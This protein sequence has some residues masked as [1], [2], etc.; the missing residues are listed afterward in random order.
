MTRRSLCR[1]AEQST[2]AQ[3]LPDMFTTGA[4]KAQPLIKTDV[5]RTAG[6]TPADVNQIRRA[7]VEPAVICDGAHTSRASSSGRRRCIR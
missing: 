7:N 5:D 3:A 6:V 1:G 2:N 4:R